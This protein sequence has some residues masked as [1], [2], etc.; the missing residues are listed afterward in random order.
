MH[1]AHPHAVRH[2]LK[3]LNLMYDV[4][5]AEYVTMVVTELGLTPPTSVPVVVR[6]T[7]ERMKD[8]ERF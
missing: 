5:P 4:T 8:L 7:Q 6:E 2:S 3:L 1:D